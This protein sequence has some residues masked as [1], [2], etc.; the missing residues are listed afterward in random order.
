MR[1]LRARAQLIRADLLLTY[2]YVILDLE[3]AARQTISYEYFKDG[4]W[5][6]DHEKHVKA[7]EELVRS[8]SPGEKVMLQTLG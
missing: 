2:R 6:Y 3:K 5:I 1:P 4:K 8:Q 7:L